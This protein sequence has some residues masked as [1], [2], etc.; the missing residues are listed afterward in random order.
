[1]IFVTRP[2]PEGEKLTEL[3]N[4][5]GLYAQHLPFFKISQGRDILKLQYQLNQLL[6]NDIVIVVSPQVTHAI[7]HNVTKLI[8]PAGIRYF[9]IGK[10]SAQLFKQFAQVDVF[11]PDREDSE[12]L[13]TLLQNHPVNQRTV[14]ILCGNSGR[15]LLEQTLMRRQAKV[16]LIE[17]YTRIPMSYRK[18]VLSKHISKQ[19]IIITSLEHLNQLESYSSN[20]HKTV[21]H[22]IVTSQRI[23]TKARELQWRNVLLIKSADNQTIFNAVKQNFSFPL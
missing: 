18:D 4:Q 21:S 14:L 9:A 17:C 6:P 7:N 20:V 2:S 10:K 22:L 3:F 12:G 8:L 13:L 23:F 11:Y 1:M 19:L 16:K 15:K 5:A